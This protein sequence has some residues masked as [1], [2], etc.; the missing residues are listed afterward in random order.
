MTRIVNL[1]PHAISVI[2]T[3][4]TTHTFEPSGTVARVTTTQ[5]ALESVSGFAVNQTVW[6]AVENLPEPTPGVVFLVSGMVLG[7]C[8]DRPDV[9]GPDSGPS[10]VRNEKG[11]IVA[12]RGF[13]K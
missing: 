10:A 6:G 12:V 13:V 9:V 4:G 8:L 11:H 7:Q 2:H 1:T 3:D 5:T